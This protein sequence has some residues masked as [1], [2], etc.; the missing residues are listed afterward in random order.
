MKKFLYSLNRVVL[1]I[2]SAIM[3]FIFYYRA[4]GSNFFFQLLFGITAVGFDLKRIE[5]WD[6]GKKFLASVFIAV[7]IIAFAGN[8]IAE[9]SQYVSTESK[10]YDDTIASITE[11]LKVA[12]E[13]QV[14]RIE[15][16]ERN[17]GTAGQKETESLMLMV[18]KQIE[19][20]EQLKENE[21]VRNDE[22]VDVFAIASQYLG[23]SLRQFLFFFFI[24]RAVLMEIGILAS[25]EK[26]RKRETVAESVIEQET[27][28][29]QIEEYVEAEK[30]E[31]QK[32]MAMGILD[33]WKE[34]SIK[35]SKPSLEYKVDM[36][37]Q[38]LEELYNFSEKELFVKKVLDK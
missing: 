5:L 1:V 26:K 19:I 18:E 27:T 14:K 2:I 16:T 4:G 24:I 3:S 31:V 35:S 25:G 32:N 34:E 23:I 12:T 7:S 22:R 17:Y 13:N 15:N 29:E 21:S 28:E 8:S 6:N 30:P 10:A 37:K 11:S 36:L 38:E 9:I 33:R 20:A